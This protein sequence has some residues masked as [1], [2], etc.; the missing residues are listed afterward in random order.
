MKAKTEN[1]R[2]DN[3]SRS[4]EQ[5]GAQKQPIVL[6]VEVLEERIAPGFLTLDGIT[7]TQPYHGVLRLGP[8]HA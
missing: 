1:K 3:P 4:G 5:R 8:E 6:N 2:T 7:P